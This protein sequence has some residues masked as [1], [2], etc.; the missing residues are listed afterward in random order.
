MTDVAHELRRTGLD[1][2]EEASRDHSAL[3]RGDPS[4]HLIQPGRVRGRAMQLPLRGGRQKLGAPWGL[5]RREVVRDHRALSPPRLADD[6]VRQERDELGRGVARRGLAHHLA[7]LRVERRV[8]GQRAVTILFE[9][10]A[11]RSPWRQG[12][13]W[14][15]TVQGLACGLLIHTKPH[16]LRRGGADTGRSH[17]RPS[18]RT[19]DRWRPASGPVGAA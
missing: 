9:A 18:A 2:G 17:R 8:Q 12:E 7:R 4:V 5:V 11:F 15:L 1:G 3:N 19:R 6:E 16:R 13:P 14:P 10:L